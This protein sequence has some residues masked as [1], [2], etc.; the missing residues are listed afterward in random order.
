MN[1]LSLDFQ[2]TVFSVTTISVIVICFMFCA[3]FDR[4]RCVRATLFMYSNNNLC[5]ETG[6]E[7]SIR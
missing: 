1:L 3:I 7:V 4:E 5:N 6:K 2:G